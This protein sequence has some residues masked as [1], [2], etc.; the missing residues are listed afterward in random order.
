MDEVPHHAHRNLSVPRERRHVLPARAPPLLM[1]APLADLRAAVLTQRPQYRPLGHRLHAPTLAR[2]RRHAA[3]PPRWHAATPPRRHPATPPRR[4]AA[5]PPRLAP[6]A[7][8]RRSTYTGRPPPARP[9]PG[10]APLRGV[11][12]RPQTPPALGAP[13]LYRLDLGA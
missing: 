11:P 8:G 13:H 4:H 2:L 10:P 1:N 5:T 12:R 3:T 6:R 9:L 7:R